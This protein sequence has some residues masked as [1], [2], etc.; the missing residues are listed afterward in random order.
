MTT[1]RRVAIGGIVVVLAWAL[2]VRW[3][4]IGDRQ[5]VVAV[6]SKATPFRL[7][8][9]GEPGRTLSL[10]DLQGKGVLLNFWATWCEPCI[11]E[12]P[13]LRTI[14]ERYGGLHFS[15]VGVTDDDPGAVKRY[16][17]KHPLPYPVVHD[18]NGELRRRFR[19]DVLPFNVFVGPDG[20]VAG[21]V[22]GRLTE[23]DAAEAVERLVILARKN[24]RGD[25]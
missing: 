13:L 3:G 14:E 16:L 11:E 1:L 25:E 10:S 19:A 12:I 22:A 18:A 7:P 24:A 23:G 6:R 17:E 20:R 21:A 9:F 5:E 2:L 15:I 4:L 8:V